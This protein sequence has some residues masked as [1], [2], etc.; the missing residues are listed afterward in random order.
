MEEV[1]KVF[2]YSMQIRYECPL[3]CDQVMALGSHTIDFLHAPL[4]DHGVPTLLYKPTIH[5]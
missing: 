2:D 1:S 3:I 4:K 5:S